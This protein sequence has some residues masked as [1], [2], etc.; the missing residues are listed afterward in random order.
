LTQQVLVQ[1]ARDKQARTVSELAD[2]L[3]IDE[4]YEQ[5]RVSTDQIRDRLEKLSEIDFIQ[6]VGENEQPGGIP[7]AH[8]FTVT[9]DANWYLFDQE[10]L[11]R[12]E[13]PPDYTVQ[14]FKDWQNYVTDEFDE[15]EK[16]AIAFILHLRESGENSSR[17]L[18]KAEQIQEQRN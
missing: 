15:L 16:Y 18:Q 4:E 8:L 12:L 10:M 3:T 13:Q 11:Y 9:E 1:L 6:K 17:L 7:D 5:A 2:A 14:S